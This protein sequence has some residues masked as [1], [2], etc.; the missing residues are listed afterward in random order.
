[1]HY[2][3]FDRWNERKKHIDTKDRIFY[4][5]EREIWWCTL[6][7]NVGKEIDGKNDVFERPVLILKVLSKE[8]FLILPLTTKGEDDRNHRKVVT[9]KVTSYAKLSQSRVVSNKRFSRRVDIIPK[10]QFKMVKSA[11]IEYIS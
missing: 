6:G 9:Q 10:D 1:M 3:D 5:K 7:I 11:F 2:K 4:V 8:T